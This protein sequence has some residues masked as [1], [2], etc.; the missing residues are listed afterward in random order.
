M[1][2]RSEFILSKT[3]CG[4]YLAVLVA[5]GL[6]YALT[7]APAILWQDSGRYVYRVWHNDIEG[8]LGLALSHPLYFLIGIVVKY[9]LPFGDLAHRIN[10]ISAVFGAVAVANLYL[11][12]R[13]WLGRVMP[14][15]VAAVTLGFCWTF[16]S[17]AV[18]AEVYTL[19]AAAL[20][21][22]LIC[23][24]QYARTRRTG[25]LYLLALLNGLSMANHLWAVFGFVCYAIL[26]LVML[27]RRRINLKNLFVVILLWVTGAGLYEYLIVKNIVLTGDLAGVLSS[28]V[29]GIGARESVLNTAVTARIVLENAIFILLNFPTPN[30]ALIFVGL[31]AL[32]NYAPDRSFAVVLVALLILHFSFAFRYSVPDRHAFFLPFY[33]LAAVLAGLG[34]DLVFRRFKSRAVLAAA[35]IFA[36]VPVAVYFVLP[37]IGRRYYKP[38]AQR[39]QRPYRDE[40]K[41]WLQ[42]WKAGYRGAERFAEEALDIVEPSAVIY[43]YTTDV[44]PLLYVQ[45][46]KGRRPDVKIVSDYDKSEN[47]PALNKSTVA[48]LV[49]GSA[50]YVVSPVKGYCPDFVIEDYDFVRVGVIYK[51][52]LKSN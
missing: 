17:N 39:R 42:P 34:A 15:V 7:C 46:V 24:F 28:T 32:K 38:L 6:F 21:A 30:I 27:A 49:K 19:F 2:K 8:K 52:E 41:Y 1:R 13:L 9:A 47:A 16:W 10:L 33:C 48:D 12:L 26:C 37:D 25:W 22:E 45:Q 20:F 50:F 5:A 29:F 43:A 3:V 18:I 14:A 31:F 40:Y 51:A 23:L 36:F 4:Q 44:H 11:L 35:I